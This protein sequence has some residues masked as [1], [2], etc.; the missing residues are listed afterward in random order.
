MRVDTP[1]KGKRIAIIGSRST[2]LGAVVDCLINQGVPVDVGDRL[3]ATQSNLGAFDC[4][5]PGMATDQPFLMNMR[6]Q[7]KSNRSKHTPHQG[8]RE[9]ERRAKRMGK[10]VVE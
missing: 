10:E 6:Q 7:G 5:P 2:T 4:L 3:I 1:K 8:K 9:M